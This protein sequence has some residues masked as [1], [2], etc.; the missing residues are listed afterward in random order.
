MKTIWF[1]EPFWKFCYWLLKPNQRCTMPISMSW[2]LSFFLGQCHS[3]QSNNT[4]HKCRTISIYLHFYA[5]RLQLLIMAT[6]HEFL[7][8]HLFYF[9]V[10]VK[11]LNKVG[12]LDCL[13][14][15][16]IYVYI[17]KMIY[18][19]KHSN[20]YLKH[21][22]WREFLLFFVFSLR[23]ILII[24]RSFYRGPWTNFIFFHFFN[25]IFFAKFFIFR[26]HYIFALSKNYFFIYIFYA[27]LRHLYFLIHRFS[28]M[29]I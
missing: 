18:P 22:N 12:N 15:I 27:I 5:M 17:Y 23:L 3:V 19:P 24:Y 29:R 14:L 9:S 16:F 13:Y 6:E 25:T 28:F 2:S 4:M 11:I 21:G 1:I 26:F 7:H 20:E 8:V 10:I